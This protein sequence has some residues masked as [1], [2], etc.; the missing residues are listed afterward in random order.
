MKPAPF[1]YHR[2]TSR[3][4]LFDLLG[5]L[6]NARVL[7]GGQS[8][9]PML[10]LRIAAPDHLIDLNAVAGLDGIELS[11]GILRIGAMTRQRAV[12][13]SPV[14]ARHLPLLGEAMRHVGFQ[15]TR[16]RGTIGGTIA[17]MDPTAEIPVVALAAD[18]TLVIESARGERSIAFA[19]LSTGYLTTQVEPD[20]A[21]VRIDF[22][23]WPE[24]H[25]SAFEEVTR[26]GESFAIV[27][28][29]VLVALDSAGRVARA[30]IAVG[31]L[32]EAP[33]RAEAAETA[34]IGHS[35]DAGAIAAAAAAAATLPA[36]GDIYAP[37]DYKQHLA[38]VLTERALQRALARAG[39]DRHV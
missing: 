7:A 34:L 1:T 12:E 30:A 6:D 4:E 5:S 9:M 25:G 20:E 15:Q 33:L 38:G 22:P 19:D 21:L 14:V 10:N 16:N 29:A 23:V 31:G 18:A 37:E 2:P 11:N 24:R 26:R 8:L 39:D 28:V 3:T 36:E 35:P 27:S 13:R 32:V 17:H